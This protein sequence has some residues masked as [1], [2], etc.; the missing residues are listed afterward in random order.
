MAKF[1]T[2]CGAT[3]S[4][5]KK[6]CTECGIPIQAESQV[7]TEQITNVQPV[8]QKT[9]QAAPPV[10]PVQQTPPPVYGADVTPAKGSRYDPITTGG[11]IGIMLLMCIPVVGLILTLVW[12]F[13][14]CKKINKRNLARATLIM[15]AIGLVISLILGLLIKSLFGA[16][17]TQLDRGTDSNNNNVTN[18][19]IQE[20][21]ELSDLLRTLEGISGEGSTN[22]LDELVDNVT[23]INTEAEAA[24]TGWPRE[25]RSYPGGTQTAVTSYRTEISGTSH[26]EM[27]EY[28]NDLKSDGYEFQDFYDMGI[29]EEDMA[30]YGWW[31]TD[32]TVY[33]SL[34]YYEGTVTID[35]MY[36]LP[37][38][39]SLMGG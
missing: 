15:T 9:V 38:L 2:K 18:Q 1:C 5:D 31:G 32:G 14:G 4:D 7:D 26:E 3:L 28:I 13:G 33:V 20:L 19:N 22:G 39:S 23:K 30:D 12:A 27:W 10:I 16:A 34:S 24:G 37:D 11:Y 21:E 17:I 29:S 8:Y 35:H 25:L 6:F 36:E